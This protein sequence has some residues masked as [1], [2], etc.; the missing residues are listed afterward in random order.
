MLITFV[1]LYWLV[2][3]NIVIVGKLSIA[4]VE[5]LHRISPE[6]GPLSR[7]CKE[8][9]LLLPDRRALGHEKAHHHLMRE[10]SLDL[11]VFNIE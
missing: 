6:S 9:E 7:L 8:N 10:S 3:F 11:L 4:V 1:R 5:P 2:S